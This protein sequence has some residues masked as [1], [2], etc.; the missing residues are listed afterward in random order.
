MQSPIHRESNNMIKVSNL[1]KAF[2]SQKA[3]DSISFEIK[4]NGITAL[5]GANGAGKTTTMRMLTCS[6]TPDYGNASIYGFDI[7]K[8]SQKIKSMIGYL[9]ERSPIYKDM[10]VYEYIK[11]I[12]KLRGLKSKILREAIEKTI[13][14]CSL[15]TVYYKKNETLSKGYLQRVALA[16]A[17]IHDPPCLI[18]DEPTDGLDPI[19]KHQVRTLIKKMGES[20][21]ILLS[22]HILDEAEECCERAMVLSLGKIVLDI[23]PS[24]LKKQAPSYGQVIITFPKENL[25]IKQI[26]YLAQKFMNELPEKINNILPIKT[27]DGFLLRIVPTNINYSQ[28][29]L[30]FSVTKLQEITLPFK[31]IYIDEGNLNEAF[32]MIK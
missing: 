7:Y 3:V 19:Q 14:L 16:Q 1:T 24:E 17:I 22:T 27:Q 29:I 26:N 11:Y 6:L 28:E 10:T 12:A 30:Q 15:E 18:L 8:M 5:L 4:K 21:I 23:T 9:P 13:S 32:R 25:T 31:N 20:K 2:N